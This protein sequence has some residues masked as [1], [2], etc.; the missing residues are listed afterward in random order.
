LPGKRA[1]FGYRGT[2]NQPEHGGG[3]KRPFHDDINSDQY[4]VRKD[5]PRA[6]MHMSLSM[7]FPMIGAGSLDQHA[8]VLR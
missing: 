2:C 5:I 7:T 6:S 4:E 8:V 3:G 1:G